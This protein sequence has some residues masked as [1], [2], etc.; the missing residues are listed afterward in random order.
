MDKDISI[1]S[2]EKVFGGFSAHHVKARSSKSSDTEE[3]SIGFEV[4]S[5]EFKKVLKSIVT[6]NW[7]DQSQRIESNHSQV[8]LH[9][10]AAVAKQPLKD[11][12]HMRFH[13]V[14]TQVLTCPEPASKTQIGSIDNDI[15]FTSN[16]QTAKTGLSAEVGQVFK[17]AAPE[18]RITKAAFNRASKTDLY[19][20]A[21]QSKAS[22]LSL[23]FFAERCPPE[24]LDRLS[25]LVKSNL[26]AL[27]THNFG[28]YLVQRMLTRDRR[29]APHL[30]RFCQSNFLLLANNEYSSRV[31]Q[32]L[33]EL[34]PSFRIFAMKSFR[35]NLCSFTEG[36]AAGF[37]VSAGILKA[38][39]EEERDIFTHSIQ[40]QTMTQL[41]ENKYFKKILVTYIASCSE[42]RL[43]AIFESLGIED[44]IFSF[45]QDKHSCFVIMKF[46]ERKHKQTASAL[47]RSIQFSP[48]EAV[49]AKFFGYFIGLLIKKEETRPLIPH[50][51]AQLRSISRAKFSCLLEEP[52]LYQVYCGAVS[53][54]FLALN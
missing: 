40:K 16:Q 30:I 48:I 34:S 23:Q 41:L 26:D 24:C 47:L 6:S 4:E 37:L 45:L 22:S 42:A 51:S 46:L 44:S 27:I 2:S 32:R 21:T 50:V 17:A 36:V 43:D 13:E 18:E 31:M 14:R 35:Y 9:F 3:A 39:S 5:C 12:V 49:S 25:E 28:S 38:H 33:M 52:V 11:G 29:L 20:W 7:T 19:N 53:V 54:M 8:N 1:G 15:K 10:K